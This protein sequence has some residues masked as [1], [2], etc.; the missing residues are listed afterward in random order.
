MT[1]DGKAHWPL[2]GEAL[3]VEP[4]RSRERQSLFQILR[5]ALVALRSSVS[6]CQLSSQGHQFAAVHYLCV[7][8]RPY[9]E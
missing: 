2:L 1:P 9:R 8:A 6:F 5:A 4:F 7:F 3:A